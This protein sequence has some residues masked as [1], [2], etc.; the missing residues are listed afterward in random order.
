MSECKTGL[1]WV[2]EGNK[3]KV[4][5]FANFGRKME[6]GKVIYGTGPDTIINESLIDLPE[7]TYNIAIVISD[8]DP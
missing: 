1:Y 7:N 6:D 3:V 8:I 5:M 4:K 2:P